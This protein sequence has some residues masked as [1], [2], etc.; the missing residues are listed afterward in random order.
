MIT[1]F[2]WHMASSKGEAVHARLDAN[3]KFTNEVPDFV[4]QHVKAADEDICA[5]LKAS[6]RLIKEKCCEAQLPI[7]LAIRYAFDLP[8]DSELVH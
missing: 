4:G 2:V 7:L 1:A 5:K 6:G 3:G 8:C